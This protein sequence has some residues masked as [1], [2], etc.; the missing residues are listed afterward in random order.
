MEN[1]KVVAWLPGT[2]NFAVIAPDGKV[3]Y[4][5]AEGAPEFVEQF[6]QFIDAACAKYGY[7]RIKAVDLPLNQIVA[8][9]QKLNGG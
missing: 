6:P 9:F 3:G 5:R 2:P 1:Y 7:K 4:V 8:F